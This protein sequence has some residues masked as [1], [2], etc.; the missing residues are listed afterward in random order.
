MKVEL[1]DTSASMVAAALVR[2]RVA[3]GSPAMGMVLTLVI[4]TDEARYYDAMRAARAIAREHPARVLG[5]VLRSGRGAANLDAQVRIGNDSAGESVVLRMSGELTQ[6]AESVVL[7]LLLPDSPV[8]AWWPGAAPKS[9]ADD[10]L[11]SLA[12]RRITDAASSRTRHASLIRVARAYQPGDTD[13]SWTRLTPWRALLAA[14]LD[15]V[16]VKITSASVMA[17]R[18]NPSADLMVAWL[19]SRLRVPV[20]LGTSKGPGMTEVRLC[21]TVGDVA[22]VRSDGRHGTYIVPGEADRAVA[23]K[24]RTTAELLAEDLRRLDEDEVYAET[25]KRLL[26]RADA[27][28]RKA[29]AKKATPKAP[30]KKTAKRTTKTSAKR[31]T[32]S[33][34]AKE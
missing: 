10:P 8:V 4:I 19:E 17:E 1:T 6:H 5:V 27:A 30:A 25:I 34:D 20:H 22:V 11:G 31:A 13:L 12:N 16:D 9:P 23:L 33:T 24:R 14:A 21:S 3:A 26:R 15:H 18:G 28:D 29:S 32:P 2:A 7:P